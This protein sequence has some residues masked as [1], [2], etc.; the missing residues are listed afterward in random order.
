MGRSD[1]PELVLDP[2][3]NPLAGGGWVIRVQGSDGPRPIIDTAPID[4]GI[5][6]PVASIGFPLDGASIPVGVVHAYAEVGVIGDDG[7]TYTWLVDDVVFNAGPITDLPIL[8]G[9]NRLTLRVANSSGTAEHSITVTGVFD[10][11]GDGLDDAW[12]EDHGF[13]PV[14]PDA[15]EEDSDGDGLPTGRE[16]MMGT[17][18]DDP[19]TDGDGFSDGLELIGS[20]DPLDPLIVAGPVHGLDDGGQSPPDVPSPTPSAVW[21]LLG[22]SAV[23]I[24]GGAFWLGRR[25]RSGAA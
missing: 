2:M 9:I 15:V 12:E 25:M 14:V 18:P 16:Y 7:S 10:S 13:D 3:V 5:P 24:V 1:A 19:D 17:D 23:L 21:V 6:P 4:F 20:G 8:P 22:A 11:D